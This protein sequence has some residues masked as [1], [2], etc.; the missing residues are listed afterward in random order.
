MTSRLGQRGAGML[1]G[2]LTA[3]CALL[4]SGPE[5]TV[6][7]FYRAL[8]SGDVPAAYAQ[9][10]SE[11]R[12]Q[13]SEDKLRLAI[14]AAQEKANSRGGVTDFSI[15]ESSV[16]GDQATVRIVETYGNGETDHG[17]VHLIREDGEWRV[18]L[19]K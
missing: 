6:E 19:E 7:R 13:I 16:E 12:L 4:A 9:L 3:A 8:A 11:S 2:M 18:K 17:T 15:L 1:L 5:A 10:A 14:A